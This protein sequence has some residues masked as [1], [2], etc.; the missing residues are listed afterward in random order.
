MVLGPFN[1]TTKGD[2]L[3][4][5]DWNGKHFL[6]DS[7]LKIWTFTPYNVWRQVGAV[8]ELFP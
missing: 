4:E 8:Q 1:T 6:I 5:F 7:R 3:Y 2:Y